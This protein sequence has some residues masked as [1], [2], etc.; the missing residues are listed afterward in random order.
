MA[1]TFKQDWGG[2]SVLLRKAFHH[3][4]ISLKRKDMIR[5]GCSRIEVA[6]PKLSVALSGTK[7][8]VYGIVRNTEDGLFSRFLFYTFRSEPVWK[9]S[10]E[11][12]IPLGD[13]F[14]NLAAE[15][16]EEVISLRSIEKFDFTAEQWQIFNAR[17]SAWLNGFVLQY[18]EESLSILKRMGLITFRVAMILSLVRQ[19]SI[20]KNEPYNESTLLCKKIDFYSAVYLIETYIHHSLNIFVLMNREKFKT[21]IVDRKIQLFLDTLPLDEFSRAAAVQSGKENV[22]LEERTVDKY[23]KKLLATGHLVQ[24]NYGKYRKR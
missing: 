6:T 16:H 4:S 22:N 14:K 7:N 2:Y 5:G 17:F 24:D 18:P 20:N 13:Y 11:D 12:E 21:S 15:L 9:D 1:D 19:G 3:E 23:L 8:Q 10:A